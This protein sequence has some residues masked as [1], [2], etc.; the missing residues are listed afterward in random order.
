MNVVIV[1]SCSVVMLLVRMFDMVLLPDWV[2]MLVEEA[3]LVATVVLVTLV[4]EV[5][6]L[7]LVITIVVATDVWYAAMAV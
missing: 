7:V 1:V 4:V 3:V 6:A 2:T 5:R